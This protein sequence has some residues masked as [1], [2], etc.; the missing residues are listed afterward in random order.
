VPVSDHGKHRS[1]GGLANPA[2]AHELLGPSVFARASFKGAIAQSV[3][4]RCTTE[5][6]G[7]RLAGLCEFKGKAVTAFAGLHQE[8]RNATF[9]LRWDCDN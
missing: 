9:Q 7:L 6:A 3:Q 4:Q 8:R 2:Q 5:R 1:G